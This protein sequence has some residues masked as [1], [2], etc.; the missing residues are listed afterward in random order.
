MNEEVKIENKKSNFLLYVCF[1]ILALNYFILFD[2][3]FAGLQHNSKNIGAE[4]IVSGV[5]YWY[6]WKRNEW[7]PI[8]GVVIGVV[9]HLTLLLLAG[10][11]AIKFA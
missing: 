8:I 5:V 1:V 3:A 7:K 10:V 4:L 2:M 6:V 9:V 11:I